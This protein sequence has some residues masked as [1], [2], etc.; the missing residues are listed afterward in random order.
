MRRFFGWIFLSVGIV[1]LGLTGLCTVVL[2]VGSTWA[3]LS[4]TGSNVGIPAA[5]WMSLYTL[6]IGAVPTALGLI[7]LFIGRSLLRDNTEERLDALLQEQARILAT[8]GDPERPS[9][10][11]DTR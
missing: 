2:M 6:A 7:P 11:P 5:V 8:R 4:S 10:G 3:N 1:W 9:D